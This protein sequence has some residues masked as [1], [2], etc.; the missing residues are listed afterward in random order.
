MSL[1]TQEQD[2]QKEIIDRMLNE[3]AAVEAEKTPEQKAQESTE[4]KTSW[5]LL[6]LRCCLINR[7]LVILLVGYS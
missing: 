7:S 6:V 1:D 4:A 2:M 3:D 5:L